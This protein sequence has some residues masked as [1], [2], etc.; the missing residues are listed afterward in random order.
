[1]QLFPCFYSVVISKRLV[2]FYSSKATGFVLPVAKASGPVG[3]HGPAGGVLNYADLE[4][5][6]VGRATGASQIVGMAIVTTTVINSVLTVRNPAG[7]STALCNY[8]FLKS[9]VI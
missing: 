3:P 6:V 9:L 2:S 5:T 7:N 4:Y 1:M 8:C